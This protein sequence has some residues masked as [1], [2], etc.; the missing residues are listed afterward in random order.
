MSAA[1][2]QQIRNAAMQA[3][4]EARKAVANIDIAAI[5]RDAMAQAR[6]ELARECKHAKPGPANETDNQAIARLAAGCVDMAEINREVQ[7]ALR[8]ATEEIQHD[9]DLSEADR[10]RALAAIDKSRA[11]MARRNTH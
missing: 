4:E 10:A 2:I 3:G 9:K 6:A 1:Q 7:D 8:E 11:E 5:T